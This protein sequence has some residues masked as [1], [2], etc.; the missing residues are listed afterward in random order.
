M[1]YLAIL[2]VCAAASCTGGPRAPANPNSVPN[3][4]LSLTQTRSAL[5][6]IYITGGLYDG[7]AA[8]QTATFVATPDD[9]VICTFQIDPVLANS[10]ALSSM[11]ANRLTVPGA[12]RA[13]SAAVL[14]NVLPPE[15]EFSN[16]FTIEVATPTGVSATVTGGGDPRFDRLVAF[17]RSNPTPC[18][19]FG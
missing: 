5:G 3:I 13:L 12:Y 2:A 6:A 10:G 7:A 8:G 9:M 15:S 16:N 11:L 14:P 19:N 1:K 17:F 4:Q 18:W